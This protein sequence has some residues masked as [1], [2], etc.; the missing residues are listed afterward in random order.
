MNF[1]ADPDREKFKQG[2]A[3]LVLVL[4]PFHVEDGH[5][6]GEEEGFCVVDPAAFQEKGADAGVC[7]GKQDAEE[8]DSESHA[9]AEAFPEIHVRMVFLL[10]AGALRAFAL[11][12]RAAG[13]GFGGGW[14]LEAASAG[15]ALDSLAGVIRGCIKVGF[16]VGARN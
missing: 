7:E 10:P 8:A 3:L 11:R 9:D 14:N 6:P 2:G 4:F 15:G 13:C 16:A 5:A 1:P 12:G